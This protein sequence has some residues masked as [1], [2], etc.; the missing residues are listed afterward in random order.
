MAFR[1]VT[2]LDAKLA[3]A[4]YNRL[5]STSVGNYSQQPMHFA[6][7]TSWSRNF[8]RLCKFKGG[9]VK[10]NLQ[11]AE[12]TAHRLEPRQKLGLAW[13]CY[14]A[15][16]TVDRILKKSNDYNL[17]RRT[18]LCLGLIYL[19][20]RQQSWSGNRYI[21]RPLRSI[22]VPSHYGWGVYSVKASA[23]EIHEAFN[24]IQPNQTQT[25][26]CMVG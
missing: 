13:G 22:Q 16:G 1:Q 25:D 26:T 15:A 24:K 14:R 8:A 18:C 12:I 11:Q 21:L 17:K 6:T 5:A 7:A 9:I 3:P 19:Q 2:Q 20:P 23:K 10:G 4:H